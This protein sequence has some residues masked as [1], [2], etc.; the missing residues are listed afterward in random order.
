M[1]GPFLFSTLRGAFSRRAAGTGFAGASFRFQ[2]R[3]NAG[4]ITSTSLKSTVF[5]PITLVLLIA[6][7]LTGYLGVWQVQRLKWKL[8]LIDEVDHNLA[9]DP[10]PLPGKI[11]FV[12][13]QPA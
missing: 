7:L 5:R 9:K 6:P 8:A 4:T 11:K 3:R 13:K 10:L 1:S 12:A 2:Q